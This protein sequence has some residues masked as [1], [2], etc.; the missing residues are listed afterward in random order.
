M[1]RL[2]YELG[3]IFVIVVSASILYTQFISIHE[4]WAVMFFSLLVYGGSRAFAL[5]AVIRGLG[6]T[7]QIYSYRVLT[8]PLI[9]IIR[10]KIAIFL[11][12]MKKYQSHESSKT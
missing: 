3:V 5:V 4:V 6:T 2:D 12:R 10:S 1:N 9:Y 8:I 7:G 11:S